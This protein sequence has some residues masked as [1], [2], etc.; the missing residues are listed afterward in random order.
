MKM[1]LRTSAISSTCIHYV[2]KNPVRGYAIT[3]RVSPSKGIMAHYREPVP[4]WYVF[5]KGTEDT[6][7]LKFQRDMETELRYKCIEL[8]NQVMTVSKV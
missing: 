8:A 5:G 3:Y 7:A 1:I 4:R 2:C 6:A